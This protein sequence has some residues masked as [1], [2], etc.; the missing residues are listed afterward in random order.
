MS[1]LAYP[2]LGA[3]LSALIAG[4]V[5]FLITVLTKEQKI[6]EFRQ[7]WIDALREDISEFLG[8][9]QSL[10]SMIGFIK[11]QSGVDESKK[12]IESNHDNFSKVTTIYFRIALRLNPDEHQEL[13]AALKEMF[14]MLSGSV[15]LYDSK[16]IESLV[17]DV[18][19]KS[20]TV[21]KKEWNRV[22]Q[23]EKMFRISKYVALIIIVI[24]AIILIGII[25]IILSKYISTLGLITQ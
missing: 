8:L 6:S 9:I 1:Y 20:Q 5:T 11:Y 25:A 14:S 17:Q 16:A 15:D 13:R 24:A 12:F 18:V 19:A 3:I 22:K 23:G 21:L 4:V 10:T 2:A 7:N